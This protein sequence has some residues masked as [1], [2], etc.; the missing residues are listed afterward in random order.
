MTQSEILVR[1]SHNYHKKREHFFRLNDAGAKFLSIVAL[2]ALATIPG[3]AGISVALISGAATILSIV[4]DFPGMAAK[5]ES[6]AT[7]FLALLADMTDGTITPEQAER[8]RREIGAREPTALRGLVQVCTDE[9]EA[10]IG[11]EVEM[12]RLTY[13]RRIAAQFGFGERAPTWEPNAG[14]N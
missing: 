4:L 1:V 14:A 9:V 12:D 5:H 11:C 10:S 6:L 3:W 13:R 7:D 8:R 2:T